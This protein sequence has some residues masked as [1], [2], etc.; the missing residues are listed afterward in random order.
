[1]TDEMNGEIKIGKSNDLP[2]MGVPV[3]MFYLPIKH[4]LPDGEVLP[5][6]PEVQNLTNYVV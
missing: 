2:P 5:P 4:W 1:M 3:I 6:V